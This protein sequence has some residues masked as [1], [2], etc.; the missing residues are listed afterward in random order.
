MHAFLDKLG[1]AKCLDWL[2]ASCSYNDSCDEQFG[3]TPKMTVYECSSRFCRL[4]AAALLLMIT[5]AGARAQ[6]NRQP[7]LSV[8]FD[9]PVVLYLNE[10]AVTFDLEDHFIDPEGDGLA[11]VVVK[12]FFADAYSVS[13]PAITPL[14]TTT[15]PQTILFGCANQA[16][17]TTVA[18]SIIVIDSTRPTITSDTPPTEVDEDSHYSFKV[19]GEDVDGDTLTY[20]INRGPSWLEIDRRTGLLS[21]TPDNDDVGSTRVVIRVI[22]EDQGY[23]EQSFDLEV[24]NVNDAPTITS[25]TPPMKVD[26]DRFYSFRVVGEDVDVNTVLEYSVT[27]GR[28]WLNIGRRTGVLSGTPRNMDVGS[29]SYVIRVSDGSRSADQSFVLEVINTNDAPTITSDTPPTEVD[30]DSH[31]SFRVVGRDVDAGDTVEFSIVDGPSWLEIDRQT[32]V[33]NGSPRNA[34]VGTTPVVV[35]VSDGSR[36]AEQS[37]DLE[38]TNVNDAPT[39]NGN[40]DTTVAENR[41]YSFTPGGGDVDVGDTLSY[42]IV[43]P[44]PWA[45]FD[46]TTGGLSG[47]PGN[48]HIGTT[49]RGIVI[50]VSDENGG[51]AS[52]D[53]FDITVTDTNHDPT[54]TSGAPPTIVAQ[55]SRYSFRVAGEDVDGDTLVYS[56][57]GAPAW[58]EIDRQTGALSGTP[59]NDDVGTTTGIVIRVADGNGS[60]AG[61]VSLAPFDLEVTDVNDEPTI[62][63]NPDTT[64]AENRAYSFTPGGGDVDV[65]DTLTYMIENPPPWATFNTAKGRLSGTPGNGHI[66]TTTRGIVISVSDGNGGSASLD[67][68]DITV[69]DTNHDPTITSSAPPANVAQDSPYSFRVVGEDVDGDT[70]EYS[71]VNGPRSSSWLSISSQGELSGT[72]GNDDVGANMGILIIV[73]DGKGGSAEQAFDLEV[74]DVNDA[75]TITSGIP[76]SLVYVDDPYPYFKVEGHDVDGDTLE[77]SF[78]SGPT[79]LEIDSRTGEL[80]GPLLVLADPTPVV[81]RV[82][83]GNGGSVEQSFFVDTFRANNDPT[84]EFVTFPNP[85]AKETIPYVPF[86]LSSSD[87]DG[88]TLTHSITGGPSWLMINSR[89]GELGGTPL[90]GDAGTTNNIV[91][92]VSDGN[93][94]IDFL[95][96]FFITV[97]STAVPAEINGIPPGSVNRG[98]PYSFT[99]GGGTVGTLTYSLANAPSWLKVDETTGNLSG[100]PG[101]DDVGTTTGIVLSVSDEDGGSASLDPFDLEVLQNAGNVESAPVLTVPFEDPIVLGLDDGDITIK[102]NDH[103]ANPEGGQVACGSFSFPNGVF[104]ETGDNPTTITPLGVGTE[105]IF[106]SC[107]SDPFDQNAGVRSEVQL[108]TIMVVDGSLNN[109]P[110]IEGTPDMSVAE[111]REYSF[112]PT[113][114]DVDAGDTLAYSITNKPPWA[115]FDEG[116][117]ALSGAPENDDVGTTTGIVISVTDGSSAGLVSLPPFDITVTNTNDRPTISGT[118][119]TRVIEGSDYSFTPGGGDVDAGDTLRYSLFNNPGW[120]MIE[121]DNGTLSGRPGSGDVRRSELILIRVSDGNGSSAELPFELEVTNI[122]DPPTIS[123]IPHTR[124]AEDSEY[125]FTPGGGDVDAGDTLA[126]SITNKPPWA[127]FDEG[128]GFLNGTPDNDDVGTTVGIVIRVSDLSGASAELPPFDIT[129]T[130]TND[131]PTIE[132]VPETS[133]AEDSEYSFTPRGRDV[134]AGDTLAYSISNQPPWADFDEGTGALR[135]TPDNDD[136]G[137]T[138]DVLISVTDGR[139][140]ASLPAFDLSVTNTN[141]APT[142]EGVPETSVVAD[143]LYSFSPAAEDDDDGDTPTFSINISPLPDWLSFDTSTGVLSGTPEPE[144]AGTITGIVISVSDGNGGEA[145]L[146]AFDLEV[147]NNAAPTITSDTPTA[148]VNEDSSYSFTVVGHDDDGD[149]LSYTITSGPDWLS[150]GRDDGVL[151]GTPDNDDVGITTGIVIR[152]TDSNGGTAEQ[153]FVLEVINTNDAPTIE[154]APETSVAEGSSYS[155]TAVGGDVDVGDTLAYSITNRPAW[156]NFDE[157]TGALSGTPGSDDVGTTTGIEIS[158]S[159]LSGASVELPP[160]DL[161][162]TNVN[163]AP[164]ITSDTPPTSV[165]EDSPYSFT[166]VGDDVDGDTLTYSIISVGGSGWLQ[167]DPDTGIMSG[168]PDNDD[169]GSTVII[170][171][172]S[173]ENEGSAQQ[174]FVLEVTNTNDPPT[175]DG[176]P[177]TTVAENSEYSFT[178]GG[179]DVD[180]GD[181]LAYSII[182]KPAWAGFEESTGALSGTPDND[183]VGTTTGIVISVSDVSGASVEL[184]PFDLTVTNVNDAPTITSDTPPTSAEEDSPYSFTVV[185]DDEDGDTL[186][187]TI[188]SGPDWLAIGRD[189]GVLSGTPDNDDVGTTPGIVISVSDGNGGS[190]EQIFELEVINTNDAP[191]ISGTPPIRAGIDSSYS[192]TPDGRDVDVGDTLTYSLTDG[193]VWLMINPQTGELSGTPDDDDAGTEKVEISVTDV[194]LASA[195]LSFNLEVFANTPPTLTREGLLNIHFNVREDIP[196]PPVGYTGHDE[197]GDTLT[198]EI[199]SG[200]SWLQIDPAT[201]ILSGTPLNEHVGTELLVVVVTDGNGGKAELFNFFTVTNTNDAPTISGIPETSVAEDSEYTFTP[202]GEDVD[203]DDTLIYSIDNLPHWAAFTLSTGV[204]RGTPD[205]DSVGTTSGIVIS[206]SDLSGTIAQLPS[207][208]ITV[209]NTN[210]APTIA[211][212]TPPTEVHEDTPYSFTVVGDDVDVGDTLTYEL[213]SAPSTG[214]LKIDPDSGILSGMPDNDDV[215]FELVVIRVSDGNGGSEGQSFVLEVINTNDAPTISGTPSTTAAENRTYSFIPGGGDVDVGDKPTYSIINKPAWADFSEVTGALRGTPDNDDVGTATGIVIS[216]SDES[217]ASAELPSFDITV[218]NTNDAPTIAGI[219]ETSVAEDSEYSFTPVGEDVD[220]GDTPTYSIINKPAWASFSEDTGSLSGTPDNDDVGTA[221]GIVISVTDGRESASLPSFDITVTNTNDA[222][223]IEGPPE[224]S[225]A[226]DSEYSFT[227]GGGDVDVGDTPTY[228]ITNKPVWADFSEGTGALSGTPDNDDVGTTTEIVISVTDGRESASLPSFDI[229]VTNTNDAPT[230]EGIPE[231]SVAEDSEYSFT[232][233]GE[234]VDVGDALEYSI[235]NKPAWADFSEGTGVLSG[236][237]DNDDVGATPGIVISVSDE[238]GASAQLPPFDITVTNTNDAPTIEGVPATIVGAGG[239][240]SFSPAVEDDDGDTPTFSI[241]INPLPDWLSFD[242]S[243]GV[244]SGTPELGDA[245]IITDIVISVSDGNGGS[246]SLDAFDLEVT[247]N[248]APTFVSDKPTTEVNEDSLYSF[249]VVGNDGDGDTLFYTIITGP[250]WLAVGRDDGVLSGTPDNGD[251]GTKSVVIRVS[252]ESGASAE[253]SFELEVINTN[254]APTIEGAPETSVAEDSEYSFIPGGGDVDV[255]DTPTYLI[256]NK[257]AWAD[258]SE[259]TGALNGTPDNDDVGS[260]S[261]IVI[262]VTDGRE[263]ASLPSFDITVTNTNDAPTITSDKPTTEVHEDSPYS[264]TVEGDDV[265]GDT[266]TYSITSGPSSGWLKI[267]PD[268]GILSGMPDNDDVGITLIFIRVSDVNGGSAEQT[269]VLEVINTN[270]APTISGTPSATVAEDNEYSFTPGG[271][272]VDVGDTPTYSIVNKPTWADFSE[273]T[274]ALSGTPDND[275]VGTTPEIVISVTDGRESASLSSFDITVTNTN[276]APTIEG[277]PETSVAEDSEYSFTPVGE[278]VDVGDT[279]IYSIINKPAWADFSDDTG[280][281]SGTPDNDDVGTTTEIVISV[282]DGRETASLPSFDITVTNTND[283]PTIAGVPE[284]IVVAGG[285]YSFSPAVEDDDGDTPTFSIN[286]NPLPDWLSFDTSTGSLSGTP[287]R[288]DA[289]IIPDIVISVSDGNGGSA[290]LDAFDLEVTLNA[291]PTFVSDKPTTEVN[292]DSLY[293][294]TVVGNDGDGDTL[295]YTISTGPDWLAIGLDDGVLSG[296]PD[297]G[298]VGTKPVVIRVSDGNGGS[299]EQSFDLEVINTNDA[300]TIEGAPETSVAEDSEYSFT[301][302]GGDV[303]VGDALEYSITGKPAW[304]SFSEGTGALGG[305]PDNDDVGTTTEIVISVSDGRE[306]AS[307]PSFDITVT[308]TNDA[309]TIEGAPETSVAEDSEYSFT[310]VG[311]DVDVGDALEYSITGKPAWASFSEGTGALSGTPDNDDVGTTLGIVISVTDGRESTSLPSFDITVSNTNDTPT[312]EGIPE[313]SVSEDSEYSFTPA[314]EDVDVGDALEYSIT[315]K[316][317]WAGFSEGTGAL[318]GTPDNDD[319]GTT[320]G[321]VISV[322]DG[323]E[324]ASLPSFDITVTNTNDAPTIAGIPETSVAEDSEYSFTPVGEDVDVGD[325]LEYSITGKPAWASF[326]EG[327]GALSGTPDN[328]DV[329]STTEIVISVT[330]GRESA[331]LPSFDITVTNT[332]DAPTIAGI[333]ETSVAEDS[334]YSF[335]PAGEDVDVG[336]TLEYSIT[337]KPAWADF[338][339]GTGVLSGTPDNDDVGTTTGIVISVTAGSESA[340]LPSFDITVTNTNDAP[341]IS[342]TPSA[343]VAEDSEYSFTPVGEDVDVGDSLEYSII[344]KPAWADFSEGTGALSGTPDN[345][346]V[347]ST[348]V[349]VISVTDGMET[350]SLPSFDITVTNTNDAPTISGIPETS[351][352]EDSE[353]S[354]TPV[355]EDVDV[356]DTLEYSITNKPA[357]ADFSEGTGALS[358][359]PD[360][361]DVGSTTEIVIS[362]TDG[363]ES[364]SLPS[365]DITVTNTNDAPTIAGIPETSVAEDSEYSFTPV[366]E[367]VDGDTP[368]FSININTLPDW[369][370]FDTSTGSL[371]GTPDNDDVGS[372][373]EIVIS[374]SD[375]RESASLPSFDITVTNTNDAPTIAGVPETSVAEDSEYSF[376]PVG[377]DVDVGDALE[378]SITGKPAWASF[379]EGTGALSGTPDNDDVGSTTEIVISVTDGRESASLP[380]FDI[381]VTNTNDAPTIAGIPETS[382]AEDSE[383]SFIPA[384]EDVDV[385]DTLEYSITNKPAWA[386]FSEGT[387]ALSGTPDNDDVG[388]TT[389]IVISVTAGS[390]SASLP[391]FD[392]TVTNTND[393]P[394]IAGI[395]E[396][397]VAEDSEYSFTPVGE[398]VDVGDSLE[399]SIINKPAWADFSEGTGA[400]SGTPDNDDVGSTTEIVISVTDGMETASLPSFDITVTNTN[401]APTIAGIP[402]TS[403]AEDSEYS[404]TPVGEDVD[405]GDTLEYSITNKPAWAGFSEG[406]GALSGTPDNDDVGSTT[407]IVISVTDGRESVS[408]PSFDITVTNTNDAPT[409]AG[410]PETSVAEDSEYSFTPAGEDVDVGDTLEYSITN[411]PAWADFSEGTGV[412]SGTPDNDDV[413]TTTGIVISVTA[414]S[415]SASLP[416][417]DITVTN[418]NDT[419]TIAGIPKTSVAED[420]EYSFTPVGEDVDVGDSLEYSIINKPAWAD[421][422]EGTGA[423]S[424]TPDNDDVGTTTGIVISVSD[425]RETASLPSFDITVTNTNDAPTISGIPETSVAEDSEYS[426]TPVGEDVDVGDTLE[427]SITNKPAWAGFSEDTGALSGTP[428]NDDVG[429]TLGIV[430]S[431]SDESGSSAHLPSFDITVTN[432]NDVP[433]ISSDSPTAEVNEDST[434][435]FTVLAN[436]VDGDT[437]SYSI[438]SGPISGW[439]Q[440]DPDTGVLSGTPDNDDVGSTSVVIRVSDENSGSAE[441]S[442]E[443]KVIN[444]NDAPTIEGAPETSVAEDSE[445][446]FVPGGRDVDVGDTPTYSIINK[447]AWAGFSEGTGALSGTPDNDDVGTTLGIVISVSDES[448]AG[449]QLPPFDITVTNTNDAPTIS[450]IP[451]TSVAEDREYSFTPVGEDVDVGDT[452]EYSITN[453]PAWA[454]FSEGTGALSGTPDNDDVGTTLGIVISVS[455]ESGAGAQL[456]PFDITVTNTND[457]PTISGIPETSVA[458]DREYSFTPVGEDVDVGDT[459]EYSITNKPAWA[460]FSEGTGSL[461]GTP[462]NDDVGTTTEIV[463]SVSDGRESASLPSFDITV[464]NTNDAPTIEGAPE[465]SVSEDSEYS[466][467]PVGEDVDVGDALEY[468]I[469]GKPAWASFSEGTGALI[470]TPDNDDV[471]TTSGIVISVTDGRESASLPSFD[472]TVT[473]T[474]DAPTIEGIPETSVAEDS[475]Y[476]FTPVGEDVDV[477]DTLEY[478][479]TNKPAWA[480]FSEGTGVLSGTPDND[481]VGTT[482]GIVISVTAG[483]ESASLPSFDITVTNTNDAPTIAGIPETSVAE[484]SEYSFTPV[485]EDV[486]VGD[487]LEYSITNKPAWAGFSEGT[488]ALSGTPDNDD[489]GTTTGIVISVTDGRESASLPSFDITVTNTN[490]APTIEGIPETS[491]AEDSEYSFTPAGEDVDVGDTLE[492]SIT[493]KPSW[494]SFSEGTGVLSGTP[495]ND[496]VGTTLGIVISVSDE[497]GASVQLPPFDIIVTNTNDAPT[498]EGIPETSVAEDSEY[499]FTPVGEDVDVGDTPT[500][501]I[502]NKPAWAGFS[503]GTGALS[504]TPDNDDVGTTLGIVISVTDGRESASLPSFDIN[505]TNTND[506]PTI[507]GIPET[508][509]AEDSEYSFTPVGEDVDVGDTPTYSIINKPAWADFSEGTGALSGTPD[510]DDV[511]TTTGIVISVTDGRETASLPSFDITVTNTNDAPTIAGIPETSVA[512]DSE[513][514][515]TPVGEDVDVGD[516]PTYSIINKPTWAD[517]SEGTGAL[518]GTPDNDDVGTTTEIVISVSDGRES[519]SLPSF[520]I[521]VT[522]TN[523]A[524]TI[525]GIPETSVAEDSEY[526]FTPVGEDVDVGDTLEYSITNKPAWASFSEGTGAL[527]GTPGNDDVGTTTGIVISVTDGRESASLPSFDITVTNTNDAPTIAGIPETSVA[528]D[529]EYSF[530]PGGGDV[531]VGDTPTYSITNKPAW[532]SFSEGTGALSGTPDNDDV[533]TTTGIV[534]SVS[535]G[536]ESASL[537]SFD[538]TVTNTNDVPVISSDSPT[539]EVNE[540]SPYFFTVL[541]NDV[542]GDTLSY[543]ITNG[544]ISGWLQIGPDTG[545]LSGTPDNDDVGSTSVEISVADENGSSAEQSFILVVVNTNDAPTI[546]GTPPTRVAQGSAYSFTPSGGDVDVGDTLE[547]S[548]INQPGWADFEPATGSLHGTLGSD[549]DAISRG[550]VI[551]VSDMNGGSASL[552]PFAITVA[553]VNSPPTISGTPETSVAQGDFYLFEPE[554]MDTDGDALAY[555]IENRPAWASFSRATGRLSGT[556]GGGDVGTTRDIV[557]S[558]TDGSSA[559]TVPLAPFDLEVTNVN[560]APTISGTPSTRVAQDDA[561]SFTPAGGDIDGDTLVYSINIDPLP[562]WLRFET[563]TGALSGTPDSG[564][565]G[566]TTGIVVSVSDGNG[567]SASLDAFDLEV[568]TTNT[569]P[570]IEGV[571]ETSVNQDGD[572][573]FIPVGV[574][575]DGD[576]LTYSIVNQP[577]W[578]DFDA[579]TGTLS[580][581]PRNE[582][583]GTTASIVISVSDGSGAGTVPLDTFAITVVDVNDA[584]TI[585]GTPPTRV[586]QG[587]G[588]SFTPEVDDVDGDSLTFTLSGGP[589]WLTIESGSLS[590]TPENRHVGTTSGIVVSVSD[591]NG[592][593]ASLD[594]FDLEVVS[595]N[596]TPTIT[597]TPATTVVQGGTYQFEPVG[598]DPD[599]D[600]L[601]YEVNITLPVWLSFDTSTGALSGTPG[602]EDVG[603]TTGIVIS[604]T[605]SSLEGMVSLPPFDLEVTANVPVEETM[606]TISQHLETNTRLILASQPKVFRRI[607]RLRS[608]VGTEQLSIAVGEVSKLVPFEFDPSSLG[609]GSYTFTT[610]LDQINR[611][612]AHLQAAPGGAGTHERRRHDVWFEGSLNKFKGGG[613]SSGDF[614]HFSLG[615]DYLLSPDLLVGGAL[616]HDRLSESNSGADSMTD[617]SGWMVAPYVTARLRENLYLDARVGGGMSETD[618]RPPGATHIDSFT[619]TRWLVD[620]GLSGELSQGQWSIRPNASLSYLSN[621]QRAYTDSLG[622]AVP[623]QT[624]SQGQLSLGPAISRQ[625]L[626]GNGWLYEPTLALDAVY[627][628]AGTSAAAVGADPAA[629]DGWRARVAP[630]LSITGNDGVGLTLTGTYDGIGQ[631]EYEAW[632]FEIN[633]GFKF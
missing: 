609:T 61:S 522:N 51:S 568:I 493:N 158:V 392:I 301:P 574:D 84:I 389:G 499:S 280:S 66:G 23:A 381:T 533:G 417:F 35:R 398:D 433:V 171:R 586:V 596:T 413:G 266:L 517:F 368:T 306:S 618:I 441:Q 407:E 619:S 341:T 528:E 576:T 623:G 86:I 625:F 189:D 77:Y 541:A 612:A 421:F 179:G 370:S 285:R 388:T 286:I 482:T 414:G 478:S 396:T 497:S 181:T 54:I 620:I 503:E 395:P 243:T 354:F 374:V 132:G 408:L 191:T 24:I 314:G 82:I 119:P 142:I 292:E 242:T 431:V 426:F 254:D 492:Y 524:P 313:T 527:R 616:Q 55:G 195:V 152:V 507:T 218:T 384:G 125:S 471:G 525:T 480:D 489:V 504:G 31:Y 410:I 481:D 378:Y 422:S 69:T 103:F 98:R 37:F 229:T 349:I 192:F 502:T 551:K 212:N 231:T 151:G 315:G 328:D 439:L 210:D 104:S 140:S 7:I 204:L 363:R 614:S 563:S 60:G 462:D 405:V 322:T 561:Y 198:Y 237:P 509:V 459:L 163:D 536:R 455:D 50:S 312:I 369:L 232:P 500:Y 390:E 557:V 230:I 149:T 327:T 357:W 200:P 591:G 275:D 434:Y 310:P 91:V 316:P 17:T 30:E 100:T 432:T 580:G 136:V 544:P 202:V 223:T 594:A 626:G 631:S 120:L 607:N 336:D 420:S 334:E 355:G 585:G 573:L 340:S 36:S 34:D 406:T 199:T 123:G 227:P 133:V 610:S 621:R 178:P 154:G 16:G 429:T 366:G 549:A 144:D 331:S 302:G 128:T 317:S 290:S 583:V 397:S 150:I 9:D 530:T 262:S 484:D 475:E 360:N 219:P 135:G 277:I 288:G 456:P 207:F 175:I 595:S 194:S 477:G 615:A 25:G 169:V 359:T 270:D 519:A 44:P 33:M 65:G 373:T 8:P 554:G 320:S 101:D 387:G 402:E 470:G 419:P 267:D 550:I 297:N 118:P 248:S 501:S 518:S 323:R 326:S 496:D 393:T 442:F 159:D 569:I 46:T 250:D 185:G 356:G 425:G 141:D 321:I 233:A 245:G 372:T 379:S 222:P 403:V 96:A 627:S 107:S 95:S 538:I 582:H 411:K 115:D 244:L 603:T 184:P 71:I 126:Y 537:P 617:S 298:D 170:I 447:P 445:Y 526:S 473:N 47:T 205:N 508:S 604:V 491:V 353:Y 339:E 148:V 251:V 606:E 147:I 307:L 247:L 562:T 209:T 469:T 400:L 365:F 49:I 225:V 279:P 386:S 584:P 32:G 241:N 318:S 305:T 39:I 130:N 401:D 114:G 13:S 64:V 590:G 282:T 495:D 463:I 278:D 376:T 155:F 62:T 235:I 188:T 361:D 599:G 10:G 268:S 246:A 273:G 415:E 63:G 391:S 352:A 257:P 78:A 383:Y 272:D 548:I 2:P 109:R 324:T 293:S 309:P 633:L 208:D 416:S 304:A 138:T 129:V 572:Y 45:S 127:D 451:E 81:I 454:S 367:D 43:N 593:S 56:I 260:T 253:Q 303:D 294:F 624:V 343:T 214:W 215:G 380:S 143:E 553:G 311:E 88:D 453:K 332:N 48:G 513:Y 211:S 375:G 532:A 546:S 385:G 12:H 83:D 80:S 131:A 335:T 75:P 68:F 238:S 252:D 437:L 592:G 494:A 162:V 284:T 487:T 587:R 506:A 632:G 134:D 90:R 276:D 99:P 197:D 52:L 122:N 289:G 629:E 112:I 512:E 265:D 505:V 440:I 436:D 94:G 575:A 450:G 597:G 161:T 579:G 444:T 166:V 139:E 74:T 601:R 93:G 598:V 264:F 362:V 224:T 377:E 117:G 263:S 428:D 430:I 483:S 622:A 424:G 458:E 485:G 15:S 540:D 348:T 412:L 146:D 547:Y 271:G 535:D 261:G 350:A 466:F 577:A 566:T 371:S 105:S 465:T 443:L 291:A 87:V 14:R 180:A 559:G 449:A 330:D 174:F 70:L 38:V 515:F 187:Y 72:P 85:N 19:E 608:G 531:D 382:V 514:S 510:N 5:M 337:N 281:L 1:R 394:T 220:V 345:D 613:G 258:F 605:D 190:A 113:G 22:K 570:T 364:A 338:S 79:W 438:T 529:S 157:G 588:Y 344:N 53:A 600:T 165:E 29:A 239:L 111:D 523:D 249:T 6:E 602:M 226:E 461:S 558:V 11:C 145:S 325:A 172:V 555:S 176:T 300:P 153:S 124:V 20:S 409:I 545:V 418:T 40:P 571:P 196:Y 57:S 156:A 299:A 42:T 89:T 221:T 351:V 578:A 308:N 58:L 556:P 457:T 18:T 217:G 296:T 193:P 589:D 67:A 228:S 486:D 452:L 521:N 183:D 467:T 167:I 110:T 611:A 542:D 446:S 319:V 427:Y 567:G 116:T 464:T 358:G 564:D 102:V 552:G 346:D 488:G 468:S 435:F 3:M 234:D 26:E 259:G 474:N 236:T 511:G 399:Y 203:V 216:V 108:I 4:P 520:D 182:N 106:F 137:T 256:I 73:S 342:G 490:D 160:F 240:Y 201:G 28:G 177:V 460:S 565:V 295:F 476:S 539:A 59:G 448:G 206:V 97:E 287:E 283:A 168:I 76:P 333:P 543:S 21:G 498:I 329:G 186:S 628:H 92:T 630:G 404:F 423:L 164:T 213:T 534:I 560:D 27:G 516:T 269:F 121:E 479:I 41:A 581:T 274:G 472:I 173:D 255:G 347:G